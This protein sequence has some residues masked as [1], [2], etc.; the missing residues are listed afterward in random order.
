MKSCLPSLVSKT[1]ARRLQTTK[2]PQV[3]KVN[4]LLELAENID[5]FGKPVANLYC[6]RCLA[7]FVSIPYVT[8]SLEG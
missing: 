6:T 1:Q 7:A 2:G 8:G 4:D 3:V 5:L